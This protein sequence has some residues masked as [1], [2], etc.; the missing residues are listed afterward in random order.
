MEF[1][2]AGIQKSSMV[3]YPG[4]VSIAVFTPYCNYDCFYCHNR[5][6]LS[7]DI[8]LMDTDGVLQFAKKRSKVIE[9]F[10]ISGGEPTLQPKLIDFIKNVR[11][12]DYKIKLDTN[13]GNLDVVKSLIENKL[14][15]YI[16]IDLKAPF[17]KYNEIC[18]GNADGKIAKQTIKYVVNSSI[19]YE[20]RTTM[21]PQLS[22]ERMLGTLAELPR[23]SRYAIQQYV[24]PHNLR[25]CDRFKANV[26]PHSTGYLEQYAKSCEH[27]CD[28]VIL[29][30]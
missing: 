22:A 27:Y 14:I 13:G 19:A 20:I 28:N 29:R 10:V 23:L 8:D 11:A 24:K 18:A 9:G 12:L 2:I 21:V 7:G 25:E 1:K 6:I 5:N 3:D 26:V 30:V 17:D 16:A 4:L 15:D